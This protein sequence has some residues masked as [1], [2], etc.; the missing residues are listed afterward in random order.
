MYRWLRKTFGKKTATKAEKE[1]SKDIAQETAQSAAKGTMADEVAEKS[2]IRKIAPYA[3]AGVVGY[4]YKDEIAQTIVSPL[5]YVA[6]SVLESPVMVGV[7]LLI[8]GG[9]FYVAFK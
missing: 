1:L 9:I 5:T 4:A 2:T 6:D 8:V 3:G 7:G